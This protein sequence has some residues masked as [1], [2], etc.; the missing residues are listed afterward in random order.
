MENVSHILRHAQKI[1][2]NRWPQMVYKW[3]EAASVGKTYE[4]VCPL[5]HFEIRKISDAQGLEQEWREQ[6]SV[7]PRN[8]EG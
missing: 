4:L 7:D 8:R 2:P 3:L 5:G 1:N 6:Q